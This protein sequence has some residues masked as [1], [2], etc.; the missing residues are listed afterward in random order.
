MGSPTAP[1]IEG[2]A[3]RLVPGSLPGARVHGHTGGEV[4]DRDDLHSSF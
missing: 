4:E 2:G 1:G 3:D